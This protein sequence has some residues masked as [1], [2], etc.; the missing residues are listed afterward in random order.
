VIG[1]SEKESKR[2]P[3]LPLSIYL[4]YL[5]D[6][7]YLLVNTCR[8]SKVSETIKQLWVNTSKYLIT[9]MSIFEIRNIIS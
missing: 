8:E 1:W 9:V 6:H 4:N 3:I 2:V 5:N 7:K